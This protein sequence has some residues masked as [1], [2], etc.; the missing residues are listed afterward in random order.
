MRTDWRTW[1]F[2]LA[3][4]FHFELPLGVRADGVGKS[5]RELLGLHLEPWQQPQVCGPNCLFVFLQMHGY[6][7]SHEEIIADTL[8][9][10]KGASLAALQA[11]CAKRG[12][13]TDVLFASPPLLNQLPMPAI[14]H[15]AL[16]G[17]KG[18]HF[19]LICEVG[20]DRVTVLDGG[21]ALIRRM[22]RDRFEARWSGYL[23]VQRKD[24]WLWLSLWCGVA[25]L[26]VFTSIY[27]LMKYRW[28]NR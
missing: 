4:W 8:V 10:E 22:P 21:T 18:E 5:Y 24:D 16:E 9:T 13:K 28:S 15:L 23:L 6:Q 1:V 19:V 2:V 20:P 7:V 25:F 12:M 17:E 27:G 11:C 14:A 26:I 3:V